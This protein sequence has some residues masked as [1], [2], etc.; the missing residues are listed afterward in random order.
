MGF[1]IIQIA[2]IVAIV[3]MIVWFP[4]TR[5]INAINEKRKQRELQ[6]IISNR[7]YNPTM[8]KMP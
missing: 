8:P 5:K 6:R 1:E 7:F 4:L 2:L 3:M